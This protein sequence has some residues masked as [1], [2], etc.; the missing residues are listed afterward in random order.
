M[1]NTLPTSNVARLQ[2]NLSLWHIIIIGLAYIQPMTLLDTFGQVSDASI[3]HVP[4]SYVFALLAVLLT[5]VSYGHMIRAYPSSGSAY[6][7]TQKA[8]NPSMGFMV[9]WSSWLDYLLS[10]LVNI[11]LAVL[12][13]EALFPSV[14]HW[15][16]VISLTALMT[17]VNLFGSKIVAYFNS[18]IVFVQ[19]AIII[20]FTFM[21]FQ[22][23]E[24]GRN[25]DGM[26]DATNAYQLWSLTPFWSEMTDIGKVIGGATILCFSFTGFD[27]LSSLAEETKDVKKTLPRAMFLTSLF[28]GIIFI[29]STYFMQLYFPGDALGYFGDAVA[30]GTQPDILKIVGGAVFQG[31]VLG[32]AIVTVMASG[33][34]AHAG[35]SRLMYVMGRDGVISKRIFGQIHPKLRTPVNNILIAGAIALTAGF[36][37]LDTV[38][39]L[40]SFGALTAFSFVN[41]SV[42]FHYALR[43]RLVKSGGDVF[44]YIIVP[45]LGFISVFLMWLE[46]DE[47]SLKVG[48]FWAA[49]GFIWL[50]IKTRG[51]KQPVPQYKEDV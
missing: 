22:Q 41:I 3:G 42:I 13:L 19:L 40:I 48:L 4:L 45:I 17:I 27:A 2:R 32:F 24:A 1:N 30:E 7:Y 35:V 10:P 11:I 5:S 39:D 8:I 14:N 43:N 38:V 37:N 31:W 25:A 49:I 46:V 21:T 33:I 20:L 16:W 29:I 36:I 12:Y 51:F 28:A 9:G 50:G 44:N 6:T 18:W 26:I 47:T 34:S 15:V 23:L